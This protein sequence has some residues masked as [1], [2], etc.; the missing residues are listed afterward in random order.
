MCFLLFPL[1]FDQFFLTK[2][3]VKTTNHGHIRDQQVKIYKNPCF[4][5]DF[6]SLDFL[7]V[8]P[9]VILTGS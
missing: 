7:T 4:V 6:T 9:T 5:F 3:T 1:S 2:M 8:F